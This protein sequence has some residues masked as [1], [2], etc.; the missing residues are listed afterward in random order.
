MFD[1]PD[2]TPWMLPTI[3]TATAILV[4]VVIGKIVIFLTTGV[5]LI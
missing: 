1:Y 5:A 3:S 4:V 2:S